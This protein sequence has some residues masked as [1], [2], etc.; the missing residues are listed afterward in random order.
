MEV[1]IVNTQNGLLCLYVCNCKYQC[2]KLYKHTYYA[3]INNLNLN[4]QHIGGGAVTRL[5]SLILPLHIAFTWTVWG[6]DRTILN[7][8]I[9]LKAKDDIYCSKTYKYNTMG[10]GGGWSLLFSFNLASHNQWPSCTN[11]FPNNKTLHLHFSVVL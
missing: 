2:L 9:H 5:V 6:R 8:D 11:I 3:G 4:C 1:G 7:A 10:M